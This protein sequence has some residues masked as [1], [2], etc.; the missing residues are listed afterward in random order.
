MFDTTV[1][2]DGDDPSS[3]MYYQTSNGRIYKWAS[4]IR[5]VADEGTLWAN[6]ATAHYTKEAK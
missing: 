1:A 6:R 2:V 5:Y 4:N 3:I